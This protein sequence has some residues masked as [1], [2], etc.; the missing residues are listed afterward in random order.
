MWGE[1]NNPNTM[2][3][4]IWPRASTTAERLWNSK[5]DQNEVELVQR[6]IDMKNE[7]NERGIGA[8]P[9]SVELCEKTPSICFD[10]NKKILP[11][12]AESP[13]LLFLQ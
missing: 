13:K 2:D 10:P 11:Q 7:L 6:L 5:I 12:P 8:A 3:D 9:I 1:V 4:Y